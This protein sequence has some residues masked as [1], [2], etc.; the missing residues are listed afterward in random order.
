MR[1]WLADAR[2]RMRLQEV[3]QPLISKARGTQCEV[4]LSRKQL[5][6]ELVTPLS[7]LA[8]KYDAEHQDEEFDQVVWKTFWIKHQRY[9]TVCLECV[10]RAKEE[11]RREAVSGAVALSDDDDGGADYPDWGPVY[12]SA[13]SR[14]IVIGWY[15]QAQQRVFGRGGRRRKQV[16][17][18]VSDDEGDEPPARFAGVGRVELSAAS[19]ALAIRWLRTARAQMQKR[20]GKGGEG[21]GG[22][23]VRRRKPGNNDKYKSGN[24]SK[25]RHK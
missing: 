14:A 16:T 19:H 18:D 12:L 13:A 23:K 9:R 7:V 17:V 10:S 3:V 5:Q 1:K 11:E 4:C 2:R 15:K 8:D 20:N 21:E 22:L 24:K 25:T 6:V